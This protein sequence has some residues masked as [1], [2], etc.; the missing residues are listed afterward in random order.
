[1][2][3]GS[4][5]KGDYVLALFPAVRELHK[6]CTFKHLILLLYQKMVLTIRISSAER[7]NNC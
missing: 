7:S 2:S 1:M 5:E 3:E 4:M 6:E